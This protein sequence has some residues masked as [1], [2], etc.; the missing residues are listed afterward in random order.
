MGATSTGHHQR[1]R[2][3]QQT[4]PARRRA[5]RPILP[6]AALALSIALTVVLIACSDSSEETETPGSP[7]LIAAG[8]AIYSG[9]NGQRGCSGCHGSDAAGARAP[10][11]VGAS[12][13]S[14]REALEISAM[15]SIDL[16]DEDIEAL[17]AY[18]NSLRE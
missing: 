9:A 8:E 15:S 7:E 12:A 1:H 18:L 11:I 14:I 16:S 6:R 5:L 2:R 17:A 3:P 10:G 13:G 4:A